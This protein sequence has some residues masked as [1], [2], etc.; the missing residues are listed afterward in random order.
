MCFAFPDVCNTPTPAGPIPIP[1][2]NIASLMMANP[3][4]CSMK[5][6]ITAMPAATVETEILLSEGDDAG[7][8]GGLI[9]GVFSGPCKFTLGSAVVFIEGNPAVFMGSL[10]G[11]NGVSSANMPMGS[12]IA[13]SQVL[14]QV[15]P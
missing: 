13:P 8:A 14:V 10:I 4:T 3:E 2:P 6:F 12:Q 5:V 11:Q 7:T 9:S 1:Y 15:A